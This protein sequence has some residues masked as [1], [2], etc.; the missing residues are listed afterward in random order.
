MIIIVHVVT[1]IVYTIPHH[2]HA[3]SP[4]WM[5]MIS[6]DNLMMIVEFCNI[7]I[8]IIEDASNK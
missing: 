8:V 4:G 5:I 3:Y 6:K 2:F 7:T 1:T